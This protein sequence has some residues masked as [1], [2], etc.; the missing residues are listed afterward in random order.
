MQV[1]HDLLKFVVR[2]LSNSARDGHNITCGDEV[3]RRCYFRVAGWLADHMKNSAIHGIYTT[4]C[5]ICES[6]QD[7]L[8]DLQKYPLRDAQQYWEWVDKSDTESLH[9]RGVKCITNALRTLRDVILR[10]LVQSYILHTILLGNLQHLLDWIKGFLE[11]H[12]RLN[13]FDSIWSSMT[14]YLGIMC[15]GS[16][17]GF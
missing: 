17:I 8:G 2:L 16:H 14:P 5:T 9:R 1:L 10:E 15:H 11:S 7:R 3:V 12:D 13:V 6:P 4:R